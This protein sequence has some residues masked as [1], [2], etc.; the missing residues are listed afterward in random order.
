M[1][2]VIKEKFVGTLVIVATLMLI[3]PSL[4][5]QEAHEPKFS[6]PKMPPT[7]AVF[8]NMG[9]VHRSQLLD[10]LPL[11]GVEPL[12]QKVASERADYASSQSDGETV[13]ELTSV[14]PPDSP[15]SE[16]GASN[17]PHQDLQLNS[18]LENISAMKSRVSVVDKP[19]QSLDDLSRLADTKEIS[20]GLKPAWQIQVA[21]FAERENAIRLQER[22]LKKGFRVNESIIKLDSKTLYRVLVGP[23]ILRSRADQ[24]AQAITEVIGEP[25]KVVRYV[26]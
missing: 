13:V 7:P 10:A 3:L 6:L 5:V 15:L 23:E 22:L 18:W 19:L 25:V 16:Q 14:L 4:T 21:S 1:N 11:S 9:V 17:L 24:I 26:P 12:S 2:Q 20:L 8:T